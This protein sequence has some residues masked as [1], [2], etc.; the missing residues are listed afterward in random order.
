MN[1]SFLYAV[2]LGSN[3][4]GKAAATPRGML[5]AALAALDDGPLALLDASQ[6]VQTRPLG[7][8]ARSYVN[9]A[10]L[11]A[12]RLAPDA[13]LERLHVIEDML[14]RRRH[15]RWGPRAIDLDLI[16]WSE[17]SFAGDDIV[18]P[19]P[20]FRAR[21]FVLEPL[22]TIAPEWHDPVTGLSIRQLSA[23]QRRAK[24]VDR[25]GPQD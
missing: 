22:L 5:T 15:Q 4:G 19:H 20:A 10:A 18:V 8:R 25:Q 13:V 24:P 21:P 6:I 23:R 7:P 11:V 17:G 3:K 1:V 16:L 2:A 14:G 12:S 9:C